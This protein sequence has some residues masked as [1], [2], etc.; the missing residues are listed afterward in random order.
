MLDNQSWSDASAELV[1]DADVRD[2]FSVF[3][4]NAL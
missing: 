3:L 4:V 1:E 2:A